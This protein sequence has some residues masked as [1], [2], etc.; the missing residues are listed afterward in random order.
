M[1]AFWASWADA[2][3]VIRARHPEPATRLIEEL[4]ERPATPF[5]S[6]AAEGR[7][8]LTGTRGFEPPSWHHAVA[9]GARPQLR[10]PAD[11]E[12]GG[13]TRVAT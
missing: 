11:F 2:L 6:A 10:D 8:T 5:L 3:G 4:E 13:V 7:R 9:D 1:P 12:A